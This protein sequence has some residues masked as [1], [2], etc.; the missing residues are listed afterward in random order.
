[1][2]WWLAGGVAGGSAFF[3]LI[4]LGLMRAA[5]SADEKTEDEMWKPHI[6]QRKSED[7]DS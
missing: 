3:L 4:T 7:V 5:K 2:A 1:M 6:Q